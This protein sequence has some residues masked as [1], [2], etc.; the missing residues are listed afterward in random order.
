MSSVGIELRR[1]KTHTKSDAMACV[2]N[3]RESREYE[4][5]THV[6]G[7]DERDTKDSLQLGTVL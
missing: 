1:Q 6:E 2:G 4:E 5:S 3:G 7:E